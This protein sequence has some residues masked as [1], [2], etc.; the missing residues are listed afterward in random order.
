MMAIVVVRDGG[1][2]TAAAGPAIV[3]G[4]WEKAP[5]V[6]GAG[7]SAVHGGVRAAGRCPAELPAAAV[8][9]VAG[10][11]GV[12]GTVVAAANGAADAAAAIGV[13]VVGCGVVA[14]VPADAPA[15]CL[16]CTVFWCVAWMSTFD[17]ID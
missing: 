2:R 6:I 4:G 14:A 11:G 15:F 8:A 3:D 13:V 1:V 10:K 5:G 16:A 12:T 7:R 17:R 9:G